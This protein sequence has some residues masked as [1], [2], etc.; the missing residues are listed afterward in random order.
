MLWY[1]FTRT[2]T[3]KKPLL[4]I[5]AKEVSSCILGEKGQNAVK[6]GFGAVDRPLQ[7][8]IICIQGIK[9]QEVRR[10][11]RTGICEISS[12]PQTVGNI[13]FAGTISFQPVEKFIFSG[14]NK[15]REGSDKS[16]FAEE[17]PLQNRNIEQ[18]GE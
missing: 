9:T 7:S 5:K 14:Y 17:N 2:Y 16:G 8:P 12:N 6:S 3:S 18:S 4:S 13:G 11:D 1:T 10:G 15:A